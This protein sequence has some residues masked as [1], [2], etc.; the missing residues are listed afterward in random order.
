MLQGIFRGHC[1]VACVTIILIVVVT[2][3]TLQTEGST[4]SNP[5]VHPSNSPKIVQKPHL[6]YYET[7]NA[8]INATNPELKRAYR[9]QVSRW[10]NDKVQRLGVDKQI[11]AKE[12]YD[13]ATEAYEVLTNDIRCDYDLHV[14]RATN[15]QY[16]QCKA[17]RRLDR[18]NESARAKEAEAEETRTKRANKKTRSTNITNEKREKGK[19]LALYTVESLMHFVVFQRH[20][21]L[22]IDL[23]AFFFH[24]SL[25][26]FL[27]F[28][29][30]HI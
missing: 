29:S 15:V 21:N 9:R 10:H 23:A 12:N 26:R 11:E 27:L 30:L 3:G 20:E 7:L 4:K 13:R 16:F 25:M 14:M 8:T 5:P 1:L 19:E 28:V 18:E 2:I 24:C 6:N 22:F 17:Q